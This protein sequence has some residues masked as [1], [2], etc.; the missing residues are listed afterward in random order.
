MKGVWWN[1]IDTIKCVLLSKLCGVPG[2]PIWSINVSLRMG[3]IEEQ[4]SAVMGMSWAL[5]LLSILNA[6]FCL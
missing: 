5:S 6:Y 3:I 2:L 4:N 1:G